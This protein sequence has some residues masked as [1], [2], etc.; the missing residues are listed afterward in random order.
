MRHLILSAS[1]AAFCF[2]ASPAS[3]L[4]LALDRFSTP[5]GPIADLTLGGG[6]V[7]AA[8][9]NYSLSGHDYTR[10][11]SAELGAR[12]NPSDHEVA[13]KSSLLDVRNSV[14]DTSF[15]TLRYALPASLDALLASQ[16]PVDSLGVQFT[17]VGVDLSLI[18]FNAILNG[19]NLGAPVFDLNNPVQFFFEIESATVAGQL[20]ITID[21]GPGYDVTLDTLLLLI[22]EGDGN[23]V[24][25]PASLALFGLGV[26]ALG[27][28]RRRAR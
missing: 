20:E 26:A 3:A 10:D 1:F 6:G 27:L 24:P 21:G 12:G 5:Q 25:A 8:A 11:L 15:V 9:V 14:G 22:N 4:I 28:G 16:S 23:V 18:N 17:V 7:S 19:V 2:T 13:I